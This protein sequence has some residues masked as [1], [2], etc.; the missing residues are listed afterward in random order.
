MHI[1]YTYMNLIIIKTYKHMTT[2]GIILVWVITLG[3]LVFS[4]FITRDLFDNI[5]NRII[6]WIVWFFSASVTFV[7][8]EF[9]FLAVFSLVMMS[10]YDE[11]ELRAPVND[12]YISHELH[13]LGCSDDFI[14]YISKDNNGD[15]VLQTMVTNNNSLEI[16][17]LNLNCFN[18]YFTDNETPRVEYYSK[19][20]IQPSMFRWIFNEPDT[21]DINLDNINKRYKNMHLKGDI[22][23]PRHMNINQHTITAWQ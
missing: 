9:V 3:I 8:L 20:E 18:F 17:D 15:A 10:A 11:G 5:R 12:S 2:F 4:G 13:S 6:K 22:Y 14:L 19:V 16:M 21:M 1:Y 7:I 23:L